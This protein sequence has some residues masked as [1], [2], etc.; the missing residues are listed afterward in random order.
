MYNDGMS[1]E[2]E[3]GGDP[4]GKTILIVDDDEDILGFLGVLVKGAGF[5]TLTASNGEKAIEQLALNPDAVI[6]D[7]NMPGCGGLGV[8]SYLRAGGMDPVPPV[9]VITAFQERHPDVQ[10]AVMDPNVAQCLRKP[11]DNDFL[12]GALH[13]YTK[14]TPKPSAGGSGTAS[15]DAKP[16]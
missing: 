2:E 10:K 3:A 15:G 4:G 13:R 1:P 8:L 5:K 14:T 12:V 9:I 11:L 6:L 7:L 16:A